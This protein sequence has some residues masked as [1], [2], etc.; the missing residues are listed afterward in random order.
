MIKLWIGLLA[1]GII[2]VLVASY[3]IFGID[4]VESWLLWAVT[5]AEAEFGSGTGKLKL[6]MV[7]DMFISKFPKL[8]AIFPYSLFSKLVDKALVSMRE[9]LKNHKIAE[10]VDELDGFFLKLK[11]GDDR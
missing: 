7:Y 2:C 11:T 3:K 9:M 8:Q 1:A 5:R 4:K 6:A 10:L